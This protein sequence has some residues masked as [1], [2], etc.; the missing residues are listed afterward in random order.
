LFPL[1]FT[2]GY[3]SS[4]RPRVTPQVFVWPPSRCASNFFRSNSTKSWF[5]PRSWFQTTSLCFGLFFVLFF[6]EISALLTPGEFTFPPPAVYALAIFTAG[7]LACVR[8]VDCA[9][10]FFTSHSPPQRFQ[11]SP[12]ILKL[13]QPEAHLF[14]PCV[15][16]PFLPFAQVLHLLRRVQAPPFFCCSPLSLFHLL[17]ALSL[18]S[19]FPDFLLF[20]CPAVWHSNRIFFTVLYPYLL[21]FSRGRLFF[22]PSPV[23]PCLG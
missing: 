17:R 3:L 18:C 1:F 5:W 2:P 21:V 6:S 8:G 7:T 23:I 13:L 10:F 15:F 12:H 11:I 22:L 14:S 4:P 9:D 19:L 20:F 16:A